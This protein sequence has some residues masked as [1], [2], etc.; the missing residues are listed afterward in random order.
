VSASAVSDIEVDPDAPTFVY[1]SFNR[2]GTGRIFR[3]QRVGSQPTSMS[4]PDITADLP[5]NLRVATIAVDRMNP[6]TLYAGTQIGVYQGRSY[7]NGATWHWTAYMNGMPAAVN[8][9]DL[10]VHPATGSL[11][12]ATFGRS[13]Y[14]VNTNFPVGS[15]LAAQGKL[16][17]LR[18]H[19]VG[20]G[21]GPST[22]FIDGEVVIQL[23]S[24]PGNAYGFQLRTDTQEYA[25]KGMLDLLRDAFDH[26]TTVRVDYERTGT[27]SGTIIRVL[28]LP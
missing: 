25:R 28:E 22:D 1:I 19:D 11:R 9:T 23:D 8:I 24:T 6:L 26:D 4:G 2:T 21:Y 16:T 17:F 12:A 7:D 3:L 5:T 13:V 18:V 14:E 20:T 10:E 15:I 27:H